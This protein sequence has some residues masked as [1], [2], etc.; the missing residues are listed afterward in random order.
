VQQSRVCDRT[1]RDAVAARGEKGVGVSRRGEMYISFLIGG[2]CSTTTR[3]EKDTATT[4]RQEGLGRREREEEEEE[5]RGTNKGRRSD[6]K[7]YDGTGWLRR[8]MMEKGDARR[9]K[10]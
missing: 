8:W 7:I 4:P 1:A 2:E 9:I 6:E 10:D 5:E 3:R